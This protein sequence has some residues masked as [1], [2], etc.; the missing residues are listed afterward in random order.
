MRIITHKRQTGYER[1]IE[2][3]GGDRGG[4]DGEKEKHDMEK[5]K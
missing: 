3:V 4:E 1:R 5:E 2:A